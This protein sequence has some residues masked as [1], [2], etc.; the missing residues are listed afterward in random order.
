MTC[1]CRLLTLSSSLQQMPKNYDCYAIK[2][3]FDNASN[4]HNKYKCWMRWYYFSHSIPTS[5]ALSQPQSSWH[6]FS[7]A[8]QWRLNVEN[9]L[10]LFMFKAIHLNSLQNPQIMCLCPSKMISISCVIISGK[11]SSSRRRKRF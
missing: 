9:F 5:A 8:A 10:F 1:R 3:K 2:V 7:T 6:I 11:K 4:A